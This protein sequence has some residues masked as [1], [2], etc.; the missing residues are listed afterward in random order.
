MPLEVE[1]GDF[2]LLLP[3]TFFWYIKEVCK[4]GRSAI[5]QSNAF[6]SSLERLVVQLNKLEAEA[7]VT[8]LAHKQLHQQPMALWRHISGRLIVLAASRCYCVDN[9]LK[10]SLS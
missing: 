9:L 4:R 6:Q 2:S 7:N 8:H 3:D 5:K 1:G 10:E